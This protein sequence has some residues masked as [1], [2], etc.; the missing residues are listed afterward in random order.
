M[1]TRVF[2]IRAAIDIGERRRFLQC[3]T[4]ERDL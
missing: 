3:L 4:E 1:G 2:E